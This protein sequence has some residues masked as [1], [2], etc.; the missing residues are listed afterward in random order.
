MGL[1]IVS[2]HLPADFH[3]QPINV[4]DIKRPDSAAPLPHRFQRARHIVPKG[5]DRTRTRNDD[6]FHD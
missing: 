1:F 5:I 6:P 4:A 2:R 3:S